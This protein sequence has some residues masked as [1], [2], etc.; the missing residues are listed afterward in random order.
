MG[1]SYAPAVQIRSGA[2]RA[3]LV[4]RTYG[5]VFVSVLVTMLGSAFAFTQ[6]RLMQAVAMHPFIAMIAIFV[7]LYM[8]QR[9]ARVF[10]KNVL[11]TLLFTFVE[12]VFIAPFLAYAEQAAPGTVSQAAL[13]T[14]AAFGGLS[15]YAT[16]SRRDFSAWGSFFIIGLIVLFVAMLINAFVASAAASLW[17]S[18]VG[19]LVFAGLL[20]F[21]TW[22]LLRSGTFGQDD[23]VIAAV[24]IYLDLLNMFLF[25]LSL[26]GNRSRR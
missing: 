1:F 4:R 19:V 17:I 20:V 23:Y 18:A 15:L 22:R 6:P 24:Q 9:N 5:L 11:L 12:G 21:D 3:T 25:I 14:F 26:L 10:P 16:L 7:P 2:E 13:L 8:A